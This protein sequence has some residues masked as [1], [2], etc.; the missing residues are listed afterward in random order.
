MAASFPAENLGVRLARKI[1]NAARMQRKLSTMSY[2][3]LQP[4]RGPLVDYACDFLGAYL[5]HASSQN[6]AKC[7]CNEI[8]KSS[9]LVT[10]R[11][12]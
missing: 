5:M 1:S 7:H 3:K 6:L 2:S 11:M 9:L 4:S 8:L 12:H 10:L